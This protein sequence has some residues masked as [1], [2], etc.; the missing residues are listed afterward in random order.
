MTSRDDE[1][2]KEK[3]QGE[4]LTSAF[5]DKLAR[6][7]TDIGRFGTHCSYYPQG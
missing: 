2:H 6:M 7:L 1:T 4:M 5:G 3:Q